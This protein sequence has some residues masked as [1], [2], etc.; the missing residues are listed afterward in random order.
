MRNGKS[1]F[2]S[3]GATKTTPPHPLIFFEFDL[4]W[5]TKRL[6]SL[7]LEQTHRPPVHRF[8]THLHEVVLL[9]LNYMA[10]IRH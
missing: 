3:T 1:V 7:C 10:C 4:I 2:V 8:M 5:L 6:C 9:L